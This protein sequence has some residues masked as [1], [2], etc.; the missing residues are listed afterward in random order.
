M[1][2]VCLNCG[3]IALQENSSDK[4][5]HGYCPLCHLALNPDLSDEELKKDLIDCIKEKGERQWQPND[6]SPYNRQVA[7][8]EEHKRR[9]NQIME[10]IKM[11]RAEAGLELKRGKK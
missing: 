1:K 11:E 7:I 5:S 6:G 10:Q 9:H 8:S 2:I 3:R 4:I